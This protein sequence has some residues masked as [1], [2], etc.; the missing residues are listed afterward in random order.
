[1]IQAQFD[2]AASGRAGLAGE[3]DGDL[4]SPA[5][6][7]DGEPSTKRR[8][9]SRE[10]SPCDSVSRPPI[11]QPCLPAGS[12][13]QVTSQPETPKAH[14]QHPSTPASRRGSA[15]SQA[16]G[17][18]PATEGPNTPAIEEVIAVGSLQPTPDEL[19]RPR[20]RQAS[21][22]V[23]A[24]NSLE[25]LGG[26]PECR[27]SESRAPSEAG[28]KVSFNSSPLSSP[29]P[30]LFDP[31]AVH[32]S[33]STT[34]G[35]STSSSESGSS[36][37][38]SQDASSRPP[39]RCGR[40]SLPN[41]KGRDLFDS[42]VWSDPLRTSVFYTFATTLR[43]RVKDVNPTTSHYF[44]SH[45]RDAG[46]LVRCYTQNIDEIEEKVGLTTSLALG[47]G[48][49]GRFSTRLG[50]RNSTGTA[51]SAP[52]LK[53]ESSTASTEERRPDEGD[54]ASKS[55]AKDRN[56]C[57]RGV[58]CVFLHGSLHSLRCFMCGLT[59]DWDEAGRENETMSGNQ[60]MCPRCEGKTAAREER[61]KRKLGVGKLR[62]DIVLYG[63]EHPNAHLISPIVQHDLSLAPDMM[64]ILGTSLKVHGL[65]VLVKEF[66]K[67]V[68]NKGG[69]VV[70]I[71]YTK[72]PDSVWSEVIDYWVQW[73]CDAWVDDLRDKKPEIW[74]SQDAVKAQREKNNPKKRKESLGDDKEP[75]Q[76]AKR[77]STEGESES[78]VPKPPPKRPMS[79]RDI[80]DN[81]AY[82]VCKISRDL[83]EYAGRPHIS[84]A[85]P[86]RPPLPEAPINRKRPRKSAPAEMQKRRKTDEGDTM[87]VKLLQALPVSRPRTPPESDPRD[88]P[89]STP[90]VDG[91]VSRGDNPTP[92]QPFE[93]GDNSIL[94]AVKSN[95]RKRK[96]KVLDG[97]EV[98]LPV[99]GQRTASAKS[100]SKPAA[101]K[102]SPAPANVPSSPC[103][104][105]ERLLPQL[106]KFTTPLPVPVIAPAP[107]AR[108]HLLPPLNPVRR[109]TG[110]ELP[111]PRIAPLASEKEHPWS[112]ERPRPT[113][114]EP[115]PNT[116][117][118]VGLSPGLG[119]SPPRPLAGR[120][121]HGAFM[122]AD[123]LAG[124][125][126]YPPVWNKDGSPSDQLRREHD[127][128]AEAALTL[129]GLREG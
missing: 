39:S 101:P 18:A 6:T 123:P 64:L 107:P 44:I 17:A 59:S 10:A 126:R 84:P 115:P 38:S 34:S 111:M 104:R 127:E 122:L 82:V 66:A 109:R 90:Q 12:E 117:P 57:N 75:K 47:P 22:S 52:G 65:K 89:R 78:S 30:V 113:P 73:D 93:P 98:S 94:A 15:V 27:L 68:H 100:R 56:P 23:D 14:Q 36:T 35:R 53:T 16:A 97:E 4:P 58:E 86:P 63:E 46:K 96:R 121:R 13:A 67:A 28:A 129:F 60:P 40:S 119:S 99:S 69:K 26:P 31:Y 54:A 108:I 77:K 88:P 7:N 110:V 50:G 32:R 112:P 102:S 91:V 45:L 128:R 83:A 80:K 87:V 51:G 103:Q 76:T 120:F 41:L 33:G 21:V 114:L 79:V 118:P 70:F 92:Q 55:A 8:R 105:P 72:P 43:Q 125:L 124:Q 48:N 2:V 95:P 61:G 25:G 85:Q 106:G 9:L 116:G 37:P 11:P 24:V 29:P 42:S 62:P 81:A 3:Q 5:A 19:L 74:L 71:N 49:K 20:S 1:M